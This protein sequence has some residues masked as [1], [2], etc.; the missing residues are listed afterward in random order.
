MTSVIP[1]PCVLKFVYQRNNPDRDRTRQKLMIVWQV[2][3]DNSYRWRDFPAEL[4]DLVEEQWQIWRGHGMPGHLVI[5][6]SWPMKGDKHTLYQI[7]FANGAIMQEN[8]STRRTRL[9]RRLV[10][11]EA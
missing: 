1:S 11:E 6:Y 3:E 8:M 2:S 10:C 9:V 7:V 5:E 4:Q